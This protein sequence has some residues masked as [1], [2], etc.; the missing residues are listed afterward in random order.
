MVNSDVIHAQ[1]S[2]WF[3]PISCSADRTVCMRT[4]EWTLLAFLGTL[5]VACLLTFFALGPESH[6][7]GLAAILLI[8]EHLDLV[9]F[10]SRRRNILSRLKT[11]GQKIVSGVRRS[12]VGRIKCEQTSRFIEIPSSKRFFWFIPELE[13]WE[14]ENPDVLLVDAYPCI[15]EFE[16]KPSRLVRTGILDLV[17]R[18]VK[19]TRIKASRPYPMKNRG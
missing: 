4:I 3:S 9:R 18:R 2:D 11:N 1:L 19:L 6:W 13:T 12:Y 7:F 8:S 15:V 17:D 5:L 14:I 16:G 10:W